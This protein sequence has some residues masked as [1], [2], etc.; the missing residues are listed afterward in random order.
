M[1]R[2]APA[3]KAAIDVCIA[4][5]GGSPHSPLAH[6]IAFAPKEILEGGLTGRSGT[7]LAKR[8][9]T[10]PKKCHCRCSGIKGIWDHGIVASGWR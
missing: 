1:I 10:T 4:V 7:G 8:I 2:N 9:E 5:R 3:A 6:S